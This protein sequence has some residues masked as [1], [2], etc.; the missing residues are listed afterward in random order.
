MTKITHLLILLL[1]LLTSMGCNK[2]YDSEAC[3]IL[4]MKKYKGV[5]TS[6]KEF[7]ANCKNFEIKYTAELCQEALVHLMQTLSLKETKKE[8]GD[9]IEHCFSESDL[10]RFSKD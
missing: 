2:E 8:F 7:E 1:L 4:S 3:N 6:Q 9:L 5:P 10:T